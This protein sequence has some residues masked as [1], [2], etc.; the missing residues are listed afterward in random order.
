MS[1]Y[2]DELGNPIIHYS[3][4][5]CLINQTK[6]SHFSSIASFKKCIAYPVGCYIKI[7]MAKGGTS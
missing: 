3:T 6:I 1:N 5:H 7:L 2:N 4:S